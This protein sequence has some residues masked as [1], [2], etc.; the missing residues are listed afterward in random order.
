MLKRSYFLGACALALSVTPEAWADFVVRDV[1]SSTSITS[2]ADADAV[3]GGAGVVRTTTAS[4]AVINYSD[5][6]AV[7]RFGGDAFFPGSAAVGASRQD[8][9][10]HA[11]ATISID[12]AGTYTFGTN[13]DDG[14]RLRIDSGGGLVDVIYDYG[15][16]GYSDNFGLVTFASAGTYA[17][18]LVFF[19]HSGE[20]AVELFAARG[21]F[22]SFSD[23]TSWQLVGDTANGGIATIGT[24]A[25]PEPASIAM[26]WLGGAAV[27]LMARRSAVRA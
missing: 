8:F 18:D 3:L 25:V 1:E 4:A 2:L 27:G 6:G 5:E 20:A 23:T 13:S 15:I 17:L 21:S 12:A 14:V 16:H 10:V 22:G 19:E 7:G 26:L 24:A 11:T 9:A